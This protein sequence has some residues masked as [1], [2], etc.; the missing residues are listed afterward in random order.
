MGYPKLKNLI[1]LE[2]IMVKSTQLLP[3]DLYHYCSPEK[4]SFVS[5]LELDTLA[6]MI[7]QSRALEAVD[8]GINIDGEGYNL[9]VMG[10]SG[11]GK[12]TLVKRFLDEHIK[13]RPQARDWTYL[14]NFVDSQKPWAVSLPA[15]Q[16]RQL[17]H[18]IEDV[19]EHLEAEIPHALDDEYYRG[20]IRAIEESARTHRVRLFGALQVEADKHGVVLLRLQDGSYAFAAKRDGEPMTSDEFEQLPLEQQEHTELAIASLHEDMQHTL[21][22]LREWERD[23]LKKVSDLN[24]EVTIEVIS[25]QI[26]KLKHAYPSSPKLQ[27]YFDAMQEDIRDNIDAFITPPENTEEASLGLDDSLLKRY[28]INLIVDNS[29]V[30]GAPIVYENLPNH[31]S[32]LGCVENMAMM[33]ALITDF[34]LI[35]A[36]A[37][38]RANGGYLILDA[39]QL[40]MQPYAWDGLKRA[41][42]AKEVQFD[43]LERMYSL[44][45]TVSLEPEPIPLDLKVILLGD[46][47]LYY[48]LYELDPEFSELFK[49]A[50]DFEEHMERTDE[51]QQLYAR[52]IA[53]TVHKEDLLHLDKL[54]V[55]RVIEHGARTIED[56]EMF[57]LHQG[58]MTDLLRE[59]AYWA[60]KN[61]AK[62][63]KQEHVQQALTAR[64]QR[65]DRMRSL[66]YQQI[67]RNITR[68]TVT[69]YT[70]GQVNA[71]SVLTVGSF[72]FAQPS[73]LTANCRFGDGDILDIEREVELGGDIHSKGVLIL[74]GYLGK[75]YAKNKPLSMS[76]S[77]VFEQSYGEVDGDSATLAELCAL[78]S[79]I[80]ELPIN[81][82]LAITGSMNQHG[83]TQAI[84]GVNEKIEGFFDV[85]QSLGHAPGQ[86]VIIPRSNVQHL[87]L[88]QDVIDAVAKGH[89]HIHAVDTAEQAL[90]LLTGMT[91]GE[92]N[93]EGK[94]PEG[95]FNAAID[96]RV[97]LWEN[98]HKH[99]K[100]SASEDAD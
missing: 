35:K 71:L 69:G 77:L 81:Q 50:A 32:L 52:L 2:K 23:N 16:G 93:D 29:A 88:R 43:T 78:L 31:Q 49:V 96:K 56:G 51:N 6:T 60:K 9:Y 34:S 53:S 75:T 4:F 95:T 10:P 47:H 7:G 40:L 33:G 73:R 99:E 12:Y 91:V 98:V 21:L 97:L 64:E 82:A 3:D 100:E 83:E 68:I 61:G 57:S 90:A 20:R 85:C 19:I 76:A 86:G 84:G 17:R 14:H 74:S 63:V 46:R 38:H 26:N 70:V 65:V 8:F 79:A 15:G 94:Y 48:Q 72:N 54:A 28:Q 92:R 24:A 22:E 37:L 87:M 59:S 55:A 27:L 30:S 41:L 89:F 45:A 13:H 66:F 25:R 62:L 1:R 58:D 18:D 80:A 42:Q 36:G 39:E 5:T 67:E 11:S 44:V